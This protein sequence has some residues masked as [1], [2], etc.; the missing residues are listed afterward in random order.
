MN[1]T[2]CVVGMGYVGL[3]LAVEFEQEG[4]DV[5]GYDIDSTKID[6][7]N[8]GIDPTNELGNQTVAA[9]SIEF[10]T[11]ESTLKQ[12]DYILVTVPTP[13]DDLKKS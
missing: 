3:P 12:A 11:D 13:V 1:K 4:F 2:I 10:T 9:S 6:Q 7:L 8:S 5:I